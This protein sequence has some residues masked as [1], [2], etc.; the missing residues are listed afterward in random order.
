[1]FD[2][3]LA[4]TCCIS[5][6][7]HVAV[8]VSLLPYAIWERVS[9]VRQLVKL[10]KDFHMHVKACQRCAFEQSVGRCAFYWRNWQHTD[11]AACRRVEMLAA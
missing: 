7:M 10:L 3:W 6:Y 2:A 8:C 1:M 5:A 9:L 11:L 4:C